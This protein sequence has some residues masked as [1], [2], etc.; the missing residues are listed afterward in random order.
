LF[1]GTEAATIGKFDVFRKKRNSTDYDRAGAV[2]E[3]EADEMR[4]LAET[5]RSEVEAWIRRNH[6]Q[7][8]T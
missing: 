6:P 4:Q 1:L 5:L 7:Y 2:S 3:T 8:L